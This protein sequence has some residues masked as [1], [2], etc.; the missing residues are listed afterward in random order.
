[1]NEAYDNES[2]A[3][4]LAERSS[5]QKAQFIRKTYVHLAFA[6]ALF[7]ALEY[8]LLGWPGAEGLAMRMTQGKSWLLV[9]LCWMG[10]SWLADKW[11]RNPTSLGIQ[12]AGLTLYVGAISVVFMPLMYMANAYFPGAIQQAGVLTAAMVLGLFAVVFTTRADFSFLRSSIVIV[13]L[14]ALGLIVGSVLFG[15]QLGLWFSLAMIALASA[16]ILYQT[17]AMLRHYR[18]DQYVS[19]ALGLFASI[20]MLYFYVLRMLMQR[21]R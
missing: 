7:A 10:V 6:L 19:A 16:A 14:L 8:L 4:E 15:F 12:Y 18:N 20:V 9:L 2:F 1:M 3:R 17:S 21:S 5:K 11:A 13:S